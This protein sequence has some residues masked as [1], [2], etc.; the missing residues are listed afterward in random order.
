MSAF[1]VWAW[2]QY[3]R[4]CGSDHWDALYWTLW[5]VGEYHK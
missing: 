1:S 5:T 2:Q 3:Y 4:Q